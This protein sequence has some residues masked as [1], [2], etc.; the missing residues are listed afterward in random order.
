[1]E[2]EWKLDLQIPLKK[3]HFYMVITMLLHNPGCNALTV[4]SHTA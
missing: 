1:M 2:N 4:W 3:H